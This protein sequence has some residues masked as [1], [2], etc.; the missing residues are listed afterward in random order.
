MDKNY[1]KSNT[2]MFLSI[3]AILQITFSL[4][5]YQ[6]SAITLFR[7]FPIDSISLSIKSPTAKNS[8]GFLCIPTPDGVPVKI[9]SPGFKVID[10]KS[11]SEIR[12]A[13]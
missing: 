6:L 11:M 3:D 5:I 1:K 8:A 13:K 4:Q 9:T 7:I 12:E 2:K 10:L